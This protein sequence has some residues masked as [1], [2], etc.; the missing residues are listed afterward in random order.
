LLFI[1]FINDLPLHVSFP[2][3]LYADDTST[4]VFGDTL[5]DLRINVNTAMT[6]INDW[7]NKNKLVVNVDKTNIVIFKNRSSQFSNL[8]LNYNQKNLAV[9]E[10]FKLL[11]LY[12]DMN[13][14]WSSHF[15]NIKP[16]LNSAIFIIRRLR[17]FSDLST[18]RIV[19]F[20]YFE[21]I[22][23]YGIVFWGNMHFIKEILILQKRIIRTMKN[24]KRY[25]S[26]REHFRNLKIMTVVN[27]Y[28]Y[29][30]ILY[31]FI[32]KSQLNLGR[33]VHIHNTRI[34]NSFIRPDLSNTPL[35]YNC[36]LTAAIR[37]YNKIPNEL[38]EINNV[39]MFKKLAKRWLTDSV[40][41][42]LSEFR[43]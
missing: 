33:D 35:F 24:L 36:F 32:N 7:F 30:C 40:F 20:S 9:Q 31:V 5:D 43:E 37:V 17:D 10:S 11:G 14:T 23:R 19:Y 29:E 3:T 22:I 38:K 15:E 12:I 26:C 39:M 8:T 41:Y 6:N 16:K 42:S 4:C 34:K 18:L 1:I 13:F 21:S 27:L 2:I 28:I 25:E